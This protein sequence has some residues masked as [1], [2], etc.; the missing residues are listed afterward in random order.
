MEMPYDLAELHRLRRKGQCPKLP[1]FVTTRWDWQQKLI[2]LG[3]LCIRVRNISDSE[4]DW[5]ALRGLHCILL[6][7]RGDYAALGQALLAASP[8][9]LE[10]FHYGLRNTHRLSVLVCGQQEPIEKIQQRDAMLE[11]L[12]RH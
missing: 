5:S 7:D 4:Q 6:C 3:A 9:Q 10:T 2:E 11:R 8:Y 1:I 12:L